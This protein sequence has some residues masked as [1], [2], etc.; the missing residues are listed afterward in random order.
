MATPTET[1][2]E[3][4]SWEDYAV[5]GDEGRGEYIDGCLVM[6]PTPTRRHQQ[7]CH[8]LA[9]ALDGVVPGHQVTL[10]WAWKPAEDEFAPDVMVHPTAEDTRFT[11][12]PR[13]VVE[14]LSKY[15]TAG[16]CNSTSTGS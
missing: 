4:M 6:S 9:Q 10:A 11:G 14:V 15:A 7:I 1:I 8:R 2:S 13:L 5:L 16:A 12:M 3:P